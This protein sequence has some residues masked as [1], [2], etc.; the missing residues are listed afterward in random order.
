MKVCGMK[1][2][3]CDG[4]LRIS[5]RDDWS[6]NIGIDKKYFVINNDNIF[7][8]IQQFFFNSANGANCAS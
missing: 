2:K 5:R 4:K 3:S 7:D 8:A 1:T 6:F